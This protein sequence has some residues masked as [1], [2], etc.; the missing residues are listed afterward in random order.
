MTTCVKHGIFF[1][2]LVQTAL[3]QKGSFVVIGRVKDGTECIS[4]FNRK[5]RASLEL[6]K[7]PYTIKE[8]ITDLIGLRVI[9]LY[10]DEI[11]TAV[12][13]LQNYFEKIEVTDKMSAVKSVPDMLGYQAYHMDLRLNPLR[14]GLAEYEQYAPYQFEI[15]IRTL[16]QDAWSQIDHKIKYKKELPPELQRRINLLSGLFEIA[17]REFMSIRDQS[18]VY[19]KKLTDDSLRKLNDDSPNEQKGVSAIEFFHFLQHQYPNESHAARAIESL[20]AQVLHCL[21]ISVQEIGAFFVQYKKY[22]LNYRSAQ[23]IRMKPLTEVRHIIFCANPQIFA[24]LLFEDQKSNFLSWLDE[25]NLN[26][27]FIKGDA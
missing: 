4:K 10:E 13:A 5:Y 16:I 2:G 22:V 20:T 26:T 23:K 18:K 15:Q 21:P 17:D 19:I 8:Y 11:T 7:T 14:R 12:L 9:C 27:P 6:S 24:N 1:V 25:N 3:E